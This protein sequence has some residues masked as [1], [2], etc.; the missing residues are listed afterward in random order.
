M[1]LKDLGEIGL[2]NRISRKIKLDA[3]V[4]RGIGDDAAVIAGVSRG[5]YML[6]TCDMLV[7]GV[8][9]TRSKAAP[10]G[11]GWKAMAR[12]LSDIAAMGGVGRYAVVSLGAP[13]SAKVSFIDGIYDGIR[14]ACGKFGVNIVGGDMSRSAK[15]IVSVSLIGEVEPRCLV[16]RSGA[17][18]GDFIFV[19][20][21]FGGSIKGKHLDFMP[22]IGEARQIV[23]N[24]RVSSMIDVTDGLIL[25]LSRVLN[26]SRAGARIHQNL[27]PL[28]EDAASF[29]DALTS[30][31]DFELLFTLPP[32]E[33][34]RF[35]KT[36]LAKMDIPVTL[37]GEVT[38]RSG[39]LT[40][41]T[42]DA[43]EIKADPKG[44]LHF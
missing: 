41:I 15:T 44:Y 24:F 26:A 12:N 40:L 37:I 20:G 19:T 17:R 13:P 25:D 10:F 39:G 2:I 28:S 30:G 32:G 7:E 33:A 9:F 43:V 1:T 22:R 35:L 29:K 23:R 31:E 6:F 4:I 27:I 21:S 8:H 42:E 5:K 14:A 16:T 18:A 36:A 3:S 34:R 11:I 38:A